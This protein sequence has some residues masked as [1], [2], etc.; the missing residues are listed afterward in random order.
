V[1][2]VTAGRIIGNASEFV[3]I[4]LAARL[5]GPVEFGRFSYTLAVA[6]VSSQFFDLG[7]ARILTIRSSLLIGSSAKSGDVGRVYGSLLGLRLAVGTALLPLLVWMGFNARWSYL[8]AGL[9]LGFLVSV[10]LSLS[11]V[12]Q[13][14]LE[15]G[16][17]ASSVYLPGTLRVAGLLLLLTSGH[18]SLRNLIIFYLI[19]HAL[20][21][22]V[23][24]YLIPWARVHLQSPVKAM[25]DLVSI[26]HFGKWLMVAAIFE[27]AYSKSDIL[28]LRF[29]GTPHDLGIYAAAFVFA[30]IFSL[31]FSSV[32]AYYVPVMCR[33]AG[34]GRIDRLKDYFLESADFLALIGIPA[35]LGV[36]AVSPTLFPLVFGEQFRASI[37]IWPI[38]ALYSG[39]IVVNQTGAVFFALEK[40]HIITIVTLGIFVSNL[41]F[42][43][44]LVPRYGAFG[45][46]WAMVIGQVLNLVFCWIAVYRLIGTIPNV[47]RMAYYLGCSLILFFLVRS[48]SIPI[49]KLDLGV[50]V[51]V[52][53]VVYAVLLFLARKNIT[54]LMRENPEYGD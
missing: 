51:L 4:V 52:G 24:L 32:V 3:A 41:F 23:L 8:A 28:S 36:W 31:I 2:G 6:A 33:A 53:V 17:Y 38:L 5:L 37:A 10:V 47:A 44:L 35:A 16:K 18:G 21:V 15:F 7:T 42:C 11:A 19:A 45:A 34:E 25:G 49:P 22:L 1:G 26:F 54:S 40:L 27:V 13:S 30:G 20:V 9:G 43:S 46:A 48:F 39:C 50:K 29:L 12:F 14:Q